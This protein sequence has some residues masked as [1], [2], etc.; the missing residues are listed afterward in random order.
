MPSLTGIFA[1]I[2]VNTLVE[3]NDQHLGSFDDPV[4]HQFVQALLRMRISGS[5]LWYIGLERPSWECPGC[6]G[7]VPRSSGS[8]KISP[9][10]QSET[11]FQRRVTP[12]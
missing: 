3:I 9:Q 12:K 4:A 6:Q 1:F 11:L 10:T 8:L 2:A 5:D 7:I